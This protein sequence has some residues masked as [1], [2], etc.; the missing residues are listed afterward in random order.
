[1]ERRESKLNELGMLGNFQRGEY[2]NRYVL[3]D[4]LCLVDVAHAHIL[5]DGICLLF[6][7]L[8]SPKGAALL[9]GLGFYHFL[10]WPDVDFL[11]PF[12]VLLHHFLQ[13]ENAVGH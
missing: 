9:P 1:M 13:R 5:R 2:T 11:H 3:S 8:H 12:T 6:H 7:F 10:D 4:L